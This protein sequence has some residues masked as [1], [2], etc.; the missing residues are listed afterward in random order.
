ME[1]PLRLY[2]DNEKDIY[3]NIELKKRWK[4]PKLYKIKF[5][6]YSIYICY[7]RLACE[8]KRGNFDKKLKDIFYDLI[9]DKK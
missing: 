4:K 8:I 6:I 1:Y 3:K 9:K 2:Y 5:I 7:Y